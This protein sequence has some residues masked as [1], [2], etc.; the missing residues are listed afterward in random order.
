MWEK[1]PFVYVNL[2]IC[3][4]DNYGYENNLELHNTTMLSA[5]KDP[6]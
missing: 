5:I 6:H 1:F 2:Q 3:W 4:L